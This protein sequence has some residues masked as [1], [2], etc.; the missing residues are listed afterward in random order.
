MQVNV[1]VAHIQQIMQHNFAHCKY[2]CEICGRYVGDMEQLGLDVTAGFS[3]V[4]KSMQFKVTVAY[5]HVEMKHNF[6]HVK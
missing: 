5:N 3:F 2:R 6:A 1:A 4:R